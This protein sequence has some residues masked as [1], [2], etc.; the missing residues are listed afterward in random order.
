MPKAIVCKNSFEAIYSSN[1]FSV[2]II[3]YDAPYIASTSY[4]QGFALARI[5]TVKSKLNDCNFVVMLGA[6]CV[7][8]DKIDDFLS[9]PGKI[10]L[11]PHVVT[12]P[13]NAA[14]FYMTGHANGDIV[15]FRRDSLEIIEWLLTQP[16]RRMPQRGMFFEQT[17]LSS[18]PFIFDDVAICKD[19]AINYAYYNFHER[20]LKKKGDQFFVNGKPLAVCQFSGYID[21]QPDKIS[22]Y[23][24]GPPPPDDVLQLFRQYEERIEAKMLYASEPPTCQNFS[25]D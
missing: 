6:D 14:K 3:D 5:K 10:V 19:V 4:L 17:L 20:T 13:K 8:Y 18:L 22:K 24:K 7:L 21:G 9:T 12:P 25:C 1:D 11:V 15:C 2:E 16:M 23:Y